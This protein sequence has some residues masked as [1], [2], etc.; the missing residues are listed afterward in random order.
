VNRLLTPQSYP[1]VDAE[2]DRFDVFAKEFTQYVGDKLTTV[3]MR[4]GERPDHVVTFFGDRILIR[5]NG[6]YAV[7]PAAE[8]TAPRFNYLYKVG[9][10]VVAYPGVRPED[11]VK[12]A[13]TR[14]ETVTRTPAWTLG[15][16]DAVVSVEGYAGG[17]ALTHID[18]LGGAK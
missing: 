10:R 9:T 7:Q 14:L 4:I 3:G 1:L 13:C 6:T 18:V 5:R 17:I 12:S 11:P 8:M 16:G 15:H 2:L